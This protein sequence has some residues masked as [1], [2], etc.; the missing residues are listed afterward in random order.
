MERLTEQQ[1]PVFSQADSVIQDN[2]FFCKTL[3]R[4]VSYSI[5]LP[6]RKVVK[7]DSFPVVLLLHGDGRT[8]R[9]I[10]DDS[11]CRRE[12][13][14]RNL[15]VVFP[16]GDRAWYIDSKTD[17]KSRYQSMLLELLEHV[18][19]NFPVYQTVRHTGI[20]GWSMGGFGA[21]HFAETY[22]D[23]V[24]AVASTIALLDYPNPR[25]PN[26]QN[27]PVSSIFGTDT[28]DWA[29]FNCL[30]NAPVLRNKPILLIAGR[31][32]F[33]YRMN[34]NFHH[35]LNQLK[36]GHTYFELEGNHDFQ[37]V[38]QSVPVMLDFFQKELG[39]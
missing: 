23:Q 20:C 26:E 2:R 11:V 7:R 28:T 12:I 29:R 35:R 27:Y 33:D 6:D 1:S 15:A 13:V 4:D 31:Q 34:Q 8:H 38:R 18:R 19:A 22:P 21:V 10:A 24:R 25:L 39:K 36:I 37:M 14:K 30:N 16:N 9:T 5:F 17:T 32:G 3:G